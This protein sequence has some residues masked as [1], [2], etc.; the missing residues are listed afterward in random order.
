MKLA[1]LRQLGYVFMELHGVDLA[2]W[3]LKYECELNVLLFLCVCFNSLSEHRLCF[4]PGFDY[5]F[6]QTMVFVLCVF[7]PYLH[8]DFWLK[9][10][11]YNT[12]FARSCTCLLQSW[13][14]MLFNKRYVYFL[15]VNL[16][17]LCCADMWSAALKLSHRSLAA[18]EQ[19]NL[20]PI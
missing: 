7:S 20:N 1:Q 11:L 3:H 12:T 13:L 17:W 18:V 15:T 2:F 5:W 4:L 9:M 14:N 10:I 19:C 6:L 16:W 8:L